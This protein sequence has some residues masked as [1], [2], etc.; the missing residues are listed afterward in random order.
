V[1]VLLADYT[2]EDEAEHTYISDWQYV[3]LTSLGTVT[4][5]TFSYEGGHSSTYGLSTP[6]YVCIDN[7]GAKAPVVDAIASLH[8]SFA[9]GDIEAYYT[10]DGRRLS[11]AQKGINVV[12]MKD[13]TTRRIY[14][15]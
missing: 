8:A 13:G 2:S 1:R 11:T 15:K 3:D 7:F 14:I 10:L 4:H 6:A 5:V 9:A 12:R